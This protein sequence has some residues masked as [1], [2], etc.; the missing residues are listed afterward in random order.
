MNKILLLTIILAQVCLIYC[1]D[2]T[3]KPIVAFDGKIYLSDDQTLSGWHQRKSSFDMSSTFSETHLV[4]TT[5]FMPLNDPVK[6]S[7]ALLVFFSD[8]IFWYGTYQNGAYISGNFEFKNDIVRLF[9]IT[10]LI[11]SDNWK[12]EDIFYTNDEILLQ[13]NNIPSYDYSYSLEN[14]I[15]SLKFAANGTTPNKTINIDI[16]GFKSKLL[17]KQGIVSAKTITYLTP[18]TTVQ[19]A[20]S[21]E[22]GCLQHITNDDGSEEYKYVMNKIEVMPNEE[23]KIIAE[24]LMYDSY[25]CKIPIIDEYYQTVKVWVPSRNIIIQE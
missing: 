1:N 16:G 18:I 11:N 13:V 2:N 24:S 21:K 8:N 15:G 10:D 4:S 6:F 14:K 23:L 19:N 22:F 7:N 25:F 12:L 3:V 9:N 5:W 20:Y 17:N